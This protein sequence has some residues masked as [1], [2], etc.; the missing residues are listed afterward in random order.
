ML[1]GRYE[2]IKPIGRGGFSYVYLCQHVRNGRLHAVKEAY[3]AGCGRV[4]NGVMAGAG[5]RLEQATRALLREVSAIC[6]LD[7]SGIVHFDDVFEANGTLCFAMDFVEGEALSSLLARR[8][9]ISPATFAD[10]AEK[11]VDAVGAL[12]AA[13]VLHGD[14]KPAN[15]ILRK[16][17]SLVLIDLGS[18]ERL[19][20]LEYTEPIV[21]PGFSAPER[22]AAGGNVGTWSD[23]YSCAATLGAAIVGTVPPDPAT[24]GPDAIHTFLET[25]RQRMP[26]QSQW[27]TGIERGLGAG[28]KDRAAD[29]DELRAALGLTSSPV[30]RGERTA[31]A[32]DGASVF[33]S[34]AH[35]DSVTVETFVRALQRRGAGVWIDRRGIK[36][37][38]RAWGAEIV[39]GMRG[40]QV[41]LLFASSSAMASDSVKEEIYLAK[42]LRK[43]ILVARL[44]DT[45]FD[46]DVHLFLTRTQH[47]AAT[48]LTPIEF[49]AAVV[50]ALG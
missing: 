35:K 27:L 26:D 22:Y 34:Y 49:A 48:S 7:H 18:A 39:K 29:I 25:G 42:D 3:A 6:R 28:V 5:S 11:L 13:D 24:T 45:P 43:P 44:D 47:L 9:G 17:K 20:D 8:R 21:T 38:S 10:I 31:T 2:V 14:I 36:P 46:D 30:S 23:V 15:I 16:D 40:S 32:S 41:V 1:N 19:S 37:G 4:G 50:A 33:V 12:H